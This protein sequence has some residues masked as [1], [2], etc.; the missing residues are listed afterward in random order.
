LS[1]SEDDVANRAIKRK[2]TPIS[3]WVSLET[4]MTIATDGTEQT[5]H[6]IR[7]ADYVHVLC[8]HEDGDMI[9]VRQFRPV[10]EVTTLE[11]PGGLREG[12][13]DPALSACREVEEETGLSVVELVPLT[14]TFAD[15]GR[16]TNRSFGF[17]ALVRGDVQQQEADVEPLKAPAAGIKHL[18]SS[19]QLS[20]PSQIALLYLAAH[21][22][23]V[24]A[25]CSQL[26]YRRPPW[27][28]Y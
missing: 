8:M 9:L 3:R 21:N 13:D 6:A 18:A 5:F 24:L 15:V 17:F 19:G 26:G 27:M 16:L 2:A 7:Q 14:E 25:I 1:H 11:L 28:E 20:I 12:N 4:V 22:Q 23:R 10:V